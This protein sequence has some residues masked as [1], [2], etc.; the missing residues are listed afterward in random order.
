MQGEE[1]RLMDQFVIKTLQ[2][3]AFVTDAGL[4]THELNYDAATPAQIQSLFNDIAYRK[5]KSVILA[6]RRNRNDKFHYYNTF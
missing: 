2:G 1:W 4:N 5:G 3:S 6:I